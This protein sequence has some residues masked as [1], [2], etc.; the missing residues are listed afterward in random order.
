MSGISAPSTYTLVSSGAEPRT[1]SCPAMGMRA[2]PAKFCTTAMGSPMA[3][4]TFSISLAVI[5][6]RL[7]SLRGRVAVTVT[8]KG[9]YEP[10][11]T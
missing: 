8:S 2:T 4:G 7:T 1:T 11:S 6:V 3:P 5:T 10:R 9:L